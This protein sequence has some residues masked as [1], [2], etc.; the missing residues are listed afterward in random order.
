M[1]ISLIG[2]V[3]RRLIL[4]KTIRFSPACNIRQL[5]ST[6]KPPSAEVASVVAC[7]N[8]EVR[9]KSNGDYEVK[10]CRLCDK[11]NKFNEDNLWKLL[12]RP[13]GSY[14]CY[15][16][17]NENDNPKT[18]QSLKN[19]LGKAGLMKVNGS[20]EALPLKQKAKKAFE[21]K[22][23]TPTAVDEVQIKS[24]VTPN[25]AESWKLHSNLYNESKLMSTLPS[26]AS[27]EPSP[28]DGNCSSVVSNPSSINS[29]S[30]LDAQVV[31]MY[32]QS[33]RRLDPKITEMYGVGLGKQSFLSDEG[34]WEERLCVSFPWMV[35][36]YDPIQQDTVKNML[37][38]RLK[39][40]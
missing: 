19:K 34:H 25:Q 3:P 37:I 20:I 16:C 36:T 21:S 1:Y 28:G 13:D 15:R 7:M 35:T 17:A 18:L 4:T 24:I 5:F 27:L 9:K 38:K 12:V 6:K 29:T 33:V 39:Y 2:I 14:H 22:P 10:I 31:Q 11:E 40:R 23:T 26:T 30:D 32:L 8:S